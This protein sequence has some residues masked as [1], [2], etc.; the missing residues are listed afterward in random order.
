MIS[1]VNFVEVET[2]LN[3]ILKDQ[4]KSKETVRIL[5][6]SLWDEWAN[7]LVDSLQDYED[8]I[9]LH[10]VNSYTMPHSFTIFKVTKSPSLVTLLK[11]SYYK[12]DRLPGIYNELGCEPVTFSI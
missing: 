9:P 7:I 5:F 1:N 6:V 4:R 11:D 2:K 12:E 10:V 8:D 3:K